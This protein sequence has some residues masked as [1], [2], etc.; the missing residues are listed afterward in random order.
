M[1]GNLFC[2]NKGTPTF[3]PPVFLLFVFQVPPPSSPLILQPWNSL[4]LPR[5]GSLCRGTRPSPY[6]SLPRTFAPFF[7]FPLSSTT[8]AHFPLPYRTSDF[9]CGGG[10]LY[11]SFGLPSVASHPSMLGTAPVVLGPSYLPPTPFLAFQTNFVSYNGTGYLSPWG[12]PRNSFQP[13][14]PLRLPLSL[15]KIGRR[16]FT[17]FFLRT[18]ASF[19]QKK[20]EVDRFETRL[21]LRIF[22]FS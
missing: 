11:S 1:F 13:H 8:T 17:P 7:P 12:H 6:V 5:A 4:L 19:R 2:E 22:K 20:P 10:P 18:L 15:V 21:L 14:L 16:W 3:Y 9:L